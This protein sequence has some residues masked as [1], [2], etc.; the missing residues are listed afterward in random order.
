[1]SSMISIVRSFGEP[2]IEL[3][4]KH[5]HIGVVCMIDELTYTRH[6]VVE[7]IAA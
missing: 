1:M 5:A 6:R 4:G 3:P 2:V 7:S